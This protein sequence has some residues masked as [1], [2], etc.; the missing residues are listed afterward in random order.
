MTRLVAIFPRERVCARHFARRKGV[1]DES[2]AGIPVE[3]AHCKGPGSPQCSHLLTCTCHGLCLVIVHMSHMPPA[4]MSCPRKATQNAKGA[5]EPLSLVLWS[6]SV[7]TT[8]SQGG[9]V[10]CILKKNFIKISNYT[11][12]WKTS[13]WVKD[14]ILTSIQ[15]PIFN[16]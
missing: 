4:F 2:R 11:T 15:N 7:F 10:C 6:S 14:E 13:E 9:P 16:T 3:P 12:I 5:E 1:L 8:S